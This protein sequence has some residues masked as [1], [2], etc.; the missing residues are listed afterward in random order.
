MSTALL[1]GRDVSAAFG[2]EV[3]H[4]KHLSQELAPYPFPVARG[5]SIIALKGPVEPNDSSTRLGRGPD[6]GAKSPSLLFTMT[7]YWLP[8]EL[9][10]HSR[11]RERP[12]CS[13][14]G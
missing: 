11:V 12:D 13:R 8:A 4:S 9:K 2:A 6:F 3:N 14:K 7:S 5:C 10:H 1:L